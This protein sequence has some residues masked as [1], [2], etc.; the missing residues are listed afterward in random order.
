MNDETQT[1]GRDT[2]LNA[3]AGESLSTARCAL[4][5][6]TLL[7]GRPEGVR[8]EEVMASIGKS[9]STAYY[10]LNAICDE[11]FAVH[12]PHRGVYRSRQQR[13]AGTAERGER[14]LAELADELF[15]RT[16]KRSYVG[17]LRRG[18]I[19]IVEVRGKQGMAR[20]PG[21][22]D[23]ISD[24]AHATAM[25]KVVLSLLRPA[26][27]DRYLACDLRQVARATLCD[28]QRLRE[29]LADV[30]RRGW[31]V[32]V[33]ELADGFCCIAAPA[34]GADGKLRAV[35]GISMSPLAFEACRDELA[36]TVCDVVGA[37]FAPPAPASGPTT[38]EEVG[39]S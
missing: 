4:R 26:A 24:L 36:R 34:F 6:L 23:R 12:D 15:A 37:S 18:A 11:G 28:P 35:V 13:V 1:P 3:H 2:V 39:V 25:G 38:L 9:R 31:A 21:L 20:Q 32:D 33:E 22:G 27:L 16:H 5:V 8:A 10:V 14:S 30:R 7:E 29:Q 19:E 17:V